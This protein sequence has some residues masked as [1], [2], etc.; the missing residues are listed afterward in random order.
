MSTADLEQRLRT[1]EAIEAIKSLKARYW[2]ALD[3]QQPLEVR[4]CLL[5]KVTLDMEGVPCQTRDSYIDFITQVGCREGYYNL[6]A[7]QNARI[8]VIGGERAEGEWDTLF[9]S[10]DVGERLVIQMTC[11]YL[12]EYVYCD[13]RWWIAAMRTRQTSFLMQR[14]DDAGLGQV[15]SLGRSN[16]NA[17]SR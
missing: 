14:F 16:A 5:P 2:R 10:I 3:Q 7:G 1:L 15:L 13:D 8:R 12:D 6:H 4:D 11:D 9:T 17:F